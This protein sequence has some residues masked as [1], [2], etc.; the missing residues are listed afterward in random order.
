MYTEGAQ[1]TGHHRFLQHKNTPTPCA[2]QHCVHYEQPYGHHGG[3]GYQPASARQTD[4]PSLDFR[5]D[6]QAP[7][8]KDVGGRAFLVDG[9]ERGGHRSPQRRPVF[10]GPGPY[11]QSDDLSQVCPWDL[12]PAQW[13][14]PLESGVRHY[15]SVREQC[16]CVV[17]SDIRAYPFKAGTLHP[18][19]HLQVKG[20]GYRHRRTV[21]YVSVDEEEEGCECTI[22]KYHMEQHGPHLGHFLIPNGH[23]GPRPVV[24]EGGEE[25]DRHQDWGRQKGGS[26]EDY[27]ER[28]GSHKGFF[29]TEV[30]QK[31]LNQSRRKGPS[32]PSSGTT[33]PETSKSTTNNDH[34]RQG[35]E[36]VKQKRRQDLV[37]DQIRQVVTDLEDVLGGLKQV[38]VEMKEVVEQI[39]RLTANI[40]LS[41][42]TACSAQGPSNNFHNSAH[43]GDLRVA[44]LPNHKPT[45]VQASQ[46]MDEDCIILRT[47]S[48]SPVHMASVVKTSCFTPPSHSRDINHERPGVNGHLPHL[49]SP[50]D[51][52]HI[53]QTHPEHHPQSLDPKVIIGNST[54]R[55]QK[56]PPYPQNGRC[57]KGPYPP[58]KPVRTPAYSGRGR[59]STSMV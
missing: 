57:G 56:P 13:S 48:P 53:G 52:N 29:P 11:G 16:G 34:Q 46:H 38:H 51:S 49:Y 26:E 4:H 59:Q 3:L 30:P 31:H 8:V 10:A 40:D 55:T 19:P 44:L 21:R 58:P 15:P 37:R 41:E 7:R 50:K 45:P 6:I 25:R 27:N 17:R 12:N 24:F 32:I 2:C 28:G 18:L 33:G 39:D 47:N 35:S 36:V 9:V 42:E 5:R 54:S 14:Y 22:E 20:Q 23:C 1:T 43:S